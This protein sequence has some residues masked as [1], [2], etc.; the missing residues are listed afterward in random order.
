MLRPRI[1][2]VSVSGL[3][4]VRVCVGVVV[5]VFVSRGAVVVVGGSRESVVF[6]ASACGVEE[7]S[8]LAM[9][10]R[11]CAKEMGRICARMK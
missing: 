2:R 3:V 11:L 7:C 8:R 4:H 6:G 10:K 5:V 1:W 9:L